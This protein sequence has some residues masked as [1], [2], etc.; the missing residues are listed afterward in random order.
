MSYNNLGYLQVQLGN[1]PEAL[2]Y[3]QQCLA[4]REEL[5]KGAPDSADFARDL[6]ASYGNLAL[7]CQ[8]QSRPGDAT[9][10]W[11]LCRQAI[12]YM[13]QRGMFVDEPVEN[14]YKQIQNL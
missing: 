4:I 7:F 14:L 8:G 12:E 2:R 5:R 10:Y 11:R 9:K 1:P 6:V 13:K 3:Y